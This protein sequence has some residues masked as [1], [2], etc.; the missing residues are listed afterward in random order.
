MHKHINCTI[1]VK[2]A[3]LYS[4]VAACDRIALITR[5]VKKMSLEL[6]FETV[7]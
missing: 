5:I 4:T 3:S 6:A 1:Q 7:H 2:A